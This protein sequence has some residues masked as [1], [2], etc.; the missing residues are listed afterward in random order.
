MMKDFRS[1][2]SRHF[3]T[4]LLL[5]VS[6]TII[7]AQMQ[8]QP[9]LRIEGG[10]HSAHINRISIDRENRFLVTGSYDKTVRIWD[11]LSGQLTQILRPPIGEGHEGKIYSVA[12]SPDGNTIAAGGWT[13]YSWDK[14]SSIY[15]FDRESGRLQKRLANLTGL[16]HF[17]T[18][19]PDGKFLAAGFDSRGGVRVFETN[20]YQSVGLDNDYAQ[21]IINT[22][23]FHPNGNRLVTGDKNGVLRL[24]EVESSGKLRRV[25]V[26]QIKEGNSI[27]NVHFSPDGERIAAGFVKL[28]NAGVFSGTDLSLLYVPDPKAINYGDFTAV[29][30]SANGQKLFGGGYPYDKKR[31][32]VIRAWNNEGRGDYKET[33]VSTS[34][35]FQILPLQKGGLVY[36][37]ARDWGIL[38]EDGKQVSKF[39]AS[40]ADY[41]GDGAGIF[42]SDAGNKVSF[43]YVT[44]G[45]FPARFSVYDRKLELGDNKKDLN[46]PVV[47][48]DGLN[49]TDWE[50]SKEPKLNGRIIEFY[51]KETSRS[52]AITPNEKSFL[53]GME[54]H[55]RLI[56]REGKELWRKSTPSVVW[57]VN[58]SR[59]GKF[60]VAAI[61][62]GTIRWYRITDGK[63]VLS[64]FPHSDRKRWILWTP[65]G[66]YDASP[67]AEDLIGWHV[68]NSTDGAAD[69]F[70]NHQFRAQFYRPDVID[71]ILQTGDETS[72]V[73]ISNEKAGR[74]DKQLTIAEILPPI[75]EINEQNTKNVTDTT[76][77]VNYSIR[78]HS[79]EKL[80]GIKAFI[81]GREIAVPESAKI[82]QSGTADITLKLSKRGNELTLIAENR[83]TKS[84]P[85]KIRLK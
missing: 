64:F 27:F 11:L 7:N 37:T 3:L 26:N 51:Y 35:I 74:K 28:K 59:N 81:D 75:I 40:T 61:G 25:A 54:N 41:R 2:I 58:A 79:G 48:A 8:T 85:A 31:G 44:N 16:V 52:L 22:V 60:A 13:G 83:F 43:Q 45:K 23:D 9:I 50:S 19:S 32:G 76:V 38:D 10:M 29:A 24:Y 14:K 46:P 56:D 4:T 6:T 12:I 18:Y 30:W 5:S 34:A 67:E 47:K 77:N 68:N 65:S 1:Y 69:F 39:E 49:I 66:Y 17:L 70:P 21:G 80:T 78:N 62:D 42:I 55:L 15:L 20:E 72:A 84:L 53:I 71:Q 63:E 33:S 57:S 73:R 36:C 82:P